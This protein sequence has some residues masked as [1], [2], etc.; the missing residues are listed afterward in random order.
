MKELTQPIHKSHR[1]INLHK[2][3][4]SQEIKPHK[5]IA[6]L[7][8]QK[9]N[10]LIPSSFVPIKFLSTNSNS[11]FTYLPTI[12]PLIYLTNHINILYDITIEVNPYL[13]IHIYWLQS[14]ENLDIFNYKII[15]TYI[16]ID[17]QI[18]V[19][20][21]LIN[22][23]ILYIKSLF[24]TYKVY[25]LDKFNIKNIINFNSHKIKSLDTDIEELLAIGNIIL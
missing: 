5:T 18:P 25:Y 13:I 24:N 14:I 9:F 6:Y 20:N 10:Q 12:K 22:Q 2:Y 11:Q 3:M 8:I 23:E 15:H 17:A 21:Q 1:S 16:P 7:L 4:T 19:D